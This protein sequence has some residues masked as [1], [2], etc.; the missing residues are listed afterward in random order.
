[1]T[2]TTANSC[3]AGCVVLCV[4][5]ASELAVLNVRSGSGDEIVRTM[6]GVLVEEEINFDR[7]ALKER[8]HEL[9]Q[10]R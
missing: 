4:P 3:C 5:T 10:V 8:G 7:D 1:M 9:R 2:R 6:D